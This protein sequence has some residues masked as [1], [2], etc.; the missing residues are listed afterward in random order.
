MG[1]DIPQ[2]RQINGF[3]CVQFC[4]RSSDKKLLEKLLR[5]EI[6]VYKTACDF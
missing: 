1:A 2:T 4:K 3:H 5:G 6:L